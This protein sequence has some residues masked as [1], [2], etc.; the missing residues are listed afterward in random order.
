MVLQHIFCFFF[1]LKISDCNKKYL[2]TSAFGGPGEKLF[3]GKSEIV[4]LEK[5]LFSFLSPFLWCL[6]FAFCLN[7]HFGDFSKRKFINLRQ[8]TAWHWFTE[9]GTYNLKIME[10]RRPKFWEGHKIDVQRGMPSFALIH[11]NCNVTNVILE[12]SRGRIRPSPPAQAVA[13][14]SVW[15]GFSPQML[16]CYT[17]RKT[18]PCVKKTCTN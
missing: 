6:Q 7:P 16:I 1:H 17:N 15:Q 4:I 11:A 10:K 13:G 5:R 2:K 8:N 18:S 12:K 14:L 9:I 3:L